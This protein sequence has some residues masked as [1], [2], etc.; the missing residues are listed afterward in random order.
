MSLKSESVIERVRARLDKIDPA[1]RQV[2][3]VYKVKITVGGNVTKSWILDLKNV[4]LYEG[5]DSAECTLICDDQA[6]LDIADKKM[7][8]KE[9]RE[10]GLL[11]V[12]GEMD[13]A[14]KLVPYIATI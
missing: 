11:S 13:L 9:A 10:K 12:E 14:M 4:K 7:E 8:A 6:F 2:T 1:N 3:N 5:D